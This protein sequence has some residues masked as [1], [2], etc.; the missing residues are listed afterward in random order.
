MNL[1]NC[2]FL[3]EKPKIHDI[4]GV[5]FGQ[6]ENEMYLCHEIF[7]CHMFVIRFLLLGL[8]FIWSLP[9]FPQGESGDRVYWINRYLSVSYPLKS[10]TITSPYGS[11]RNPFTGEKSQ[12]FGLDLRA[13]EE[14]VMSMFD[15]EVERIGYDEHS[16]KYLRICHGDYTISYC[17]LS[18]IFVSE[19]DEVFAGDAVGISGN[20]GKTTGP[21]LH[22][23]VRRN[24]ELINPYALLVYIKN[25]REES[26]KML[27]GSLSSMVSCGKSDRAA[28][29]AHYAGIAMEQQKMYGIPSSVTLAQLAFESAWGT[30]SLAVHGNN[31]F[32]IKCSQEWLAAGKPYSLHNDDKPNEKFCNY[33]SVLESFVH[34][35]QLLMGERYKRCRNYPSTDYHNWLVNIKKCGYATNPNYVQ[36]CEKLIRQYKLYKYDQMAL[37]A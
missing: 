18:S 36:L 26:V 21:H 4:L 8:I 11:R 14:E 19:G 31:L 27:G 15:G 6:L 2:D 35:S 10:V 33:G 25:V 24:G 1:L 3:E 9:T 20:T 5:E 23:T 28:F 34:H 30:S 29:F 37:M 12:H 16:G 13:K 17:H 32:G 7:H 22:I